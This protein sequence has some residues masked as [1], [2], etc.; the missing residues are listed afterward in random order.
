MQ[1]VRALVCFI[2]SFSGGDSKDLPL[3]LMCHCYYMTNRQDISNYMLLHHGNYVWWSI[4]INNSMEKA[5][6]MFIIHCTCMLPYKSLEFSCMKL[7]KIWVF[8]IIGKDNDS[9]TL[10]QQN[11]RHEWLKGYRDLIIQHCLYFGYRS[12][13]RQSNQLG[14]SEVKMYFYLSAGFWW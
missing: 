2:C 14:T 12:I 5:F 4:Y 11:A 10:I 7:R 3:V 6:W 8:G 9:T 13:S 1:F